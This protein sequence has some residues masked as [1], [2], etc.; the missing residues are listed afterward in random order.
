MARD[1]VEICGKKIPL[2]FL[3]GNDLSNLWKG[4]LGCGG[5]IGNIKWP[6]NWCSWNVARRALGQVFGC[7]SCRAKGEDVAKE[8]HHY[9]IFSPDII[10]T[11][12][13]RF[14]ELRTKMEDATVDGQKW[15]AHVRML[16]PSAEQARTSAEALGLDTT[17]KALFGEGGLEVNNAARARDLEYVT[18]NSY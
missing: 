5:A 13:R 10:A 1:G 15:F 2:R 8:C 7:R 18:S 9:D 3:N 17:D 11:M 4:T 14:E 6:C 12:Q 16:T